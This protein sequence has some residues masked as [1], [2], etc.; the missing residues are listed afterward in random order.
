MYTRL[1]QVSLCTL[2]PHS[3]L[4]RPLFG[5]PSKMDVQPKEVTDG[6][7]P[8]AASQMPQ[9]QPL[10]EADSK[11]AYQDRQLVLLALLAQPALLATPTLAAILAS[12][13]LVALVALLAPF[14][15]GTSRKFV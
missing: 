14:V 13:A 11:E 12:P 10:P 3:A 2:H 4:L 8:H 15:Y 1:S 7:T 5:P 9:P 6:R